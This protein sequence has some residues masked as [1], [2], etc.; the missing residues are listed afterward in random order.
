MG[1]TFFGTDLLSLALSMLVSKICACPL[2]VL[3]MNNIGCRAEG[4]DHGNGNEKIFRVSQLMSTALQVVNV[5]CTGIK[6]S[7]QEF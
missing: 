4:A 6:I 5:L 1:D 2:T 3:A 7:L